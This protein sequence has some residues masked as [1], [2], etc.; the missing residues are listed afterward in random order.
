MPELVDTARVLWVPLE[1]PRGAEVA[2]ARLD[3]GQVPVVAG[4]GV[5]D[6]AH[7]LHEAGDVVV[8][9]EVGAVGPEPEQPLPFM[10]PQCGRVGW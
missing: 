9:W 5:V 2:D 4:G 1:A 6:E 7:L 8:R 3:A 10:A